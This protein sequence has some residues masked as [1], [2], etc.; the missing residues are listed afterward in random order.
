MALWVAASHYT[1][2]FS[3]HTRAVQSSCDD[4]SDD[5]DCSGSLGPPTS[6]RHT[7][8]LLQPRAAG[9][10]SAAV[11]NIR[12]ETSL[13]VILCARQ[14]T[15]VTVALT[16]TPPLQRHMSPSPLLPAV[17]A[18]PCVINI[19]YGRL[20]AGYSDLYTQ[21]PATS[22]LGGRVSTTAALTVRMP[23]LRA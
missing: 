13:L 11:R 23:R 16:E 17:A 2:L 15:H 7:G 14:F 5:N 8:I 21:P 12:Q 3:P 19:T 22:R 20:Y 10:M 6:A 18:A 4:Y 1:N 9:T